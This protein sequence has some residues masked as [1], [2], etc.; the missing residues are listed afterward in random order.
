ML[1]L[2]KSYYF[3]ETF[4]KN[5][6]LICI[7]IISLSYYRFSLHF[8]ERILH[9]NTVKLFYGSLCCSSFCVALEI[10]TETV[11][12][13][14]LRK[15]TFWWTFGFKLDTWE[16]GASTEELFSSGCLVGRSVGLDCYRG[17]S[18][19]FASLFLLKEAWAL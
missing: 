6:R 5:N 4:M 11:R 7:W 3:T 16:E 2:N 14:S 15:L 9:T 13:V 8:N 18:P 19:S 17:L 12:F 10:H 1:E